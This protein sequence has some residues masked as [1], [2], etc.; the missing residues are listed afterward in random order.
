MDESYFLYYEEL[1]WCEK[2]RKSGLRCWFHGQAVIYHKESI[3]V[4]KASA[5]KTYFMARNRM[6]FIRK[7]CSWPFVL[8]FSLFFVFV[9]STKQALVFLRK[10]R[11]DLIKWHYKGIW[12]NLT[13][14]TKSKRLGFQT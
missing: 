10:G 2:F 8:F 5:L 7:N 11:A 9:S 13:H 14:G 12:W 6:L 3:S 4:G 1:D